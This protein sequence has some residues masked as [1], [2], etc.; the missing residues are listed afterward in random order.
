MLQTT[1]APSGCTAHPFPVAPLSAD[2][3]QDAVE[4]LDVFRPDAKRVNEL[5]RLAPDDESANRLRAESEHVY[6]TMVACGYV[7]Q[8]ALDDFLARIGNGD[9]RGAQ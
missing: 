6:R 4:L 2:D 1:Q 3:W 8:L 7:E 9:E 5:L